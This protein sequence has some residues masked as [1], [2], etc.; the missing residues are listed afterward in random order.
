MA[1]RDYITHRA[2]PTAPENARLGDEYYDTGT[3]TLRKRVAFNGTTVGWSNVVTSSSS[4]N[5][6]V[7]AS[8]GSER[9]EVNGG[10]RFYGRFDETSSNRGVFV[11]VTD[12]EPSDRS[13]DTP[14]VGFFNG[15]PLQNW[16]I[17]NFSGTFRWYTPGVSRMTIDSNGNLSVITGTISDS[18]GNVRDLVNNAQGG[19]YI[20]AA[21]DNGKLINI[22]TGGVT[23]NAGIFSAGNNVTIFNNSATSQTITQGSVTMYLAGTATTGNR[24]LAQRGI[25]TIVC[26]AANT[27]VISGSGLS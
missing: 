10:A 12:N 9:F 5:V 1:S 27:F 8:T 26:V 2:L 17:D 25:A 4:G 18:A 21:S 6:Y 14:R 13:N 24:T 7:N 22:T 23:V 20:L 15:N 19:A 16:Q 3:N 11:G